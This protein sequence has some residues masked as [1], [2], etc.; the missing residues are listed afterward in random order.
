[1]RYNAVRCSAAQ[2]TVGQGSAMQ[3]IAVH[4]Q[5]YLRGLHKSQKLCNDFWNAF[6]HAIYVFLNLGEANQ[7]FPLQKY[8]NPSSILPFQGVDNLFLGPA[9]PENSTRVLRA[10]HVFRIQT[11]NGLV[12][13]P[14]FVAYDRCCF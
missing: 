5:F 1:M 9:L 8:A 3:G 13:A 14:G 7:I 6:K 12:L 2:C 11:R 4:G 10:H